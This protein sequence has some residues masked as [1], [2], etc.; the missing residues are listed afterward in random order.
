MFFYLPTEHGLAIVLCLVGS[1]IANV[2]IHNWRLKELLGL[3]TG[4]SLFLKESLGR[5]LEVAGTGGR[6]CMDVED[7]L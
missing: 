3:L 2:V 6:P 7:D 1:T 4:T 5:A